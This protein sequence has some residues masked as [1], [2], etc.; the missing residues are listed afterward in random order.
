MKR[1]GLIILGGGAAG[2]AAAMR[3]NE[4]KAKTL[5]IN[6]NIVGIGEL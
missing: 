6:N 4:L 2:F 1:Y 3:A 5:M